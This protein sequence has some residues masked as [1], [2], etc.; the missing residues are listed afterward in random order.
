MA[1]G[2]AWQLQ[3]ATKWL[4]LWEEMAQRALHSM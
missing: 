2:D 1:A 4:A 3:M